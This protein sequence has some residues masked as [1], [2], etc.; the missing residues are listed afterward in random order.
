[1]IIN[2]DKEKIE[3]CQ[4][5]GK[6]CNV[7][8]GRCIKIPVSKI[9]NKKVSNKCNKE[10]IELC[11]KKGKICNVKSGRCI[12]IPVSKINNKKVSNKCNKEKIELCQKKMKICNV[13]SGRCIKIPVSKINNKKMKSLTT[14]EKL[15]KLKKIWRTVKLNN[16]KN[17]KEKAFKIVAKHLLPFITK[18][19]SLSNRIK[20]AKQVINGFYNFVK[21]SDIYSD[22]INPENF[23]VNSLNNYKLNNIHLYKKIGSDS[24]YGSI[25]NVKYKINSKY[26][27]LCG[28]IMCDKSYNREEIK[29]LEK[30]TKYTLDKKTPHFPIMYYNGYIKKNKSLKT[31]KLLL[32]E[33][34]R[35]C[36]N[37]II[38]FNEM[39][40]GDLE[41]F[42]KNNKYSK[43]ILVNSLEQIFISILTFHNTINKSHNDCHWGNFLY[44]RIKPGGYIHYN[45]FDKDIYLKNY[46]YLWIIWDYGLTHP[47]NNYNLFTDYKRVIHAF[48]SKNDRGWNNNLTS[49]TTT[50]INNGGISN[51]FNRGYNLR[52]MLNTEEFSTEKELFESLF[53]YN[54]D[55]N[56]KPP[57][58][59]I[60]N[61]GNTFILK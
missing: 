54:K 1:M 36:D 29:I 31:D 23:K 60:V 55:L 6:I 38:N 8:S 26:Y 61:F 12:K 59:E 2:C 15:S 56:I 19:F 52:K 27:N 22:K 32:P 47:L 40:T 3:L 50:N 20:Y 37:F 5:K 16:N 4:K 35:K 42:I 44:H 39:F 33:S 17:S 7:K 53:N 28:K 11:Q 34:V 43:N 51:V 9:N 46:G 25:Y 30:V 48:I 21:K 49:V 24:V 58:S 13:K 14:P 45:I 41:T 57:D 10:K 18:T